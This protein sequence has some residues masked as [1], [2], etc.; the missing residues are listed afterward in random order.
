VTLTLNTI[1]LVKGIPLIPIHFFELWVLQDK[2][3]PYCLKANRGEYLVRDS[4]GTDSLEP[5]ETLTGSYWWLGEMNDFPEHRV[6]I[7]ESIDPETFLS[8]LENRAWVNMVAP[9]YIKDPKITLP[10]EMPRK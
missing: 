8:S 6:V 9:L 7:D 2:P 3:L 10:K 5:V 1:A 4:Q